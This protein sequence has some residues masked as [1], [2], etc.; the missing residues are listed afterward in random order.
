MFERG[1]STS[2]LR[3][4][5][6][7]RM[8][9]RKSAMGSVI[10]MVYFL[11]PA[12]LD[13]ARDIATQGELAEAKAA[14]FELAEIRARP[15]AALAAVLCANLELELLGKPIDQLAHGFL[16]GRSSGSRSC[17]GR[18][19]S[20]SDRRPEWHTE[21]PQQRAPFGV[22]RRGGDDRDVHAF[23]RIDL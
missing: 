1:H 6:P 17:D 10:D 15:A 18:L 9:A 8:R 19:R 5:I 12:R 3:A 23:D 14:H 13:D 4:R 22:G 21:M 2:C 7:L 16:L 20:G 11:S